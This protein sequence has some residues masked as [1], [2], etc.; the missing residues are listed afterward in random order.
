MTIAWDIIKPALKTQIA[1]AAELAEESVVFFH[2][3]YPFHGEAMLALLVDRVRE[4]GH[5]EERWDPNTAQ[6]LICGPREFTLTVLAQSFSE[7]AQ[8]F[9]DRIKTRLQRDTSRTALNAAELAFL[10]C[11][12][13]RDRTFESDG[14]EWSAY[15]YDMQFA[16]VSQEIDTQY[17]GGVIES[18]DLNGVITRPDGSEI[19]E[20]ITV[21]KP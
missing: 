4:L 12:E 8:T 9:L 2:K 19:A 17:D 21:V 10:E 11:D 5:D 18:V 3:G 7:F 15:G 14:R 13:A 6:F 20:T 1:L 16:T